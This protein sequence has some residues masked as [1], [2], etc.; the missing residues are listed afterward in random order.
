MFYTKRLISEFQRE[1]EVLMFC[2]LH[3]HSKKLN[4]FIYGCNTAANGG[5]LTWTKVRLFPRV[6]ARNT[7]LFAFK[8]CR[9]RV[10]LNKVGTARVVCWKQF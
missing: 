1:R 8:D 2:D 4:S 6:L 5:F 7:H 3:G 9:F 10:E